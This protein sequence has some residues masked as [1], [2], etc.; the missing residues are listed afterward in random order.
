MLRLSF[1]PYLPLLALLAF[2]GSSFAQAADR[3]TQTAKLGLTLTLVNDKGKSDKITFREADVRIYWSQRKCEAETREAI[4]PCK[5]DIK[6]DLIADSGEVLIKGLPKLHFD[7]KTLDKMVKDLGIVDKKTASQI[8]KVVAESSYTRVD[9]FDVPWYAL[10]TD[11]P[12]RPGDSPRFWSGFNSLT[13]SFPIYAPN[14]LGQSQSL[15]LEF[16]LHELKADAGAF[17][18]VNAND[19]GNFGSP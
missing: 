5:L 17:Q 7:Q 8:F 19:A 6:G 3:P 12:Y 2:W 13:V 9:G 10:R 18:V 15:L 4:Y 11:L 16:R 14:T 1:K